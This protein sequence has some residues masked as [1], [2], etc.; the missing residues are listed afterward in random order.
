[1][2]RRSDRIPA[3]CRP[4]VV[5]SISISCRRACV[6]T[7]PVAAPGIVLVRTRDGLQ[8]TVLYLF[9]SGNQPTIGY[10]SGSQTISHGV[11]LSAKTCLFAIHAAVSTLSLEDHGMWV[12]ESDTRLLTLLTSASLAARGITSRNCICISKESARSHALQFA[13]LSSTART[14]TLDPR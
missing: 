13:H 6:R 8:A 5:P 7:T 14:L 11:N 3:L 10:M 2:S 4:P 1:M 9:G 12:S